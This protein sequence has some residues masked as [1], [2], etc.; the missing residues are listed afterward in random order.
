MDLDSFGTFWN[1]FSCSL[2]RSPAYSPCLS[3][4]TIGNA[5]GRPSISM[6]G[7]PWWTIEDILGDIPR[8]NWEFDIYAASEN[9]ALISHL[10]KD[11]DAWCS[12]GAAHGFLN[13]CGGCTDV[14][15]RKA[16]DFSLYMDLYS[17]YIAAITLP[18]YSSCTFNRFQYFPP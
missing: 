15:Q 13:S 17:C 3:L 6:V 14:H 5:L 2:R 12:P 9:D 4:L 16:T 10:A 18:Q 7:G 8:F 1:P 11:L